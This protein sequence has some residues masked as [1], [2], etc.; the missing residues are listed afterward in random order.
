VGPSGRSLGHWA[1][2]LEDDCGTLVSSSF[3]SWL[4]GEYFIPPYAPCCCHLSPPTRGSKQLICS[5]LEPLK[6]WTKNKPFLFKSYSSYVLIIVTESW[7]THIVFSV[8]F[9]E[10]E[11]EI[12]ILASSTVWMTLGQLF[13]LSKSQFILWMGT[14]ILPCG[15]VVI[16][17]LYTKRYTI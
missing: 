12:Q 2:A 14:T 6:L 8:E 16:Y 3:S 17:I 7:L 1:H 9:R 5:I 4:W 11:T 13:I 10:K 15:D